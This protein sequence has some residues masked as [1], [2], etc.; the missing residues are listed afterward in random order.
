MAS[1]VGHFESK[2]NYISYLS[3]VSTEYDEM[4]SDGRY[5]PDRK[6]SNIYQ[7]FYLSKETLQDILRIF[8]NL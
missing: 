4:I 6:I 5:R 3:R 8:L 1:N 7:N 2:E